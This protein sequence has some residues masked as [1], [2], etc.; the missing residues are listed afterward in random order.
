M[1]TK[2]YREDLAE[3][4]I[5]NNY[6]NYFIDEENTVSERIHQG[7]FF[8]GKGEYREIYFE[9]I[10]IGYGTMALAQPTLIQFESDFE[11]VEMHFA[12]AGSSFTTETNTS[13]EIAFAANQHN[14]IFAPGFKGKSEWA[15]E[16]EMKI[17]EVNLLPA[18][19]KKYLPESNQHFKNFKQAIEKKNL[20]QLATHNLRITPQMHS[21]IWEIVHCNRVGSFKKMLIEAKVIELLLLQLEQFEQH[22]CTTF[23]NLKKAD[24]DKMYQAKELILQKINEPCS[25]ISLAREVGTNEFTLKKGFKEVFGT[26]VFGFIQ[27]LKMEEAKRMLLQEQLAIHQVSELVGYKNPQHFTVAF[28]KKFGVSPKELRVF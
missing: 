9:G 15:G 3:M 12:L 21:I 20:S 8:F 22:D 23:C 14:I 27:D 16:K 5:E 26:T 18:F 28:K 6:P 13:F 7:D 17:F 4:L 19:F 25:L 24:I 11:T 10:H 1:K 2:I